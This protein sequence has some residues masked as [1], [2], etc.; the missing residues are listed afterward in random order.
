MLNCPILKTVYVLTLTQPKAL[1]K[2]RML[3][4]SAVVF[5]LNHAFNVTRIY[6]WPTSCC[7]LSSLIRFQTVCHRCFQNETANDKAD[8]FRNS[9]SVSFVAIYNASVNV[10]CWSLLLHVNVYV[11]DSLRHADK[12]C[13]PQSD[14]EPHCLLQ[15]FKRTS[16]QL[17]ADDI[18]CESGSVKVSF[19]SRERSS[20]SWGSVEKISKYLPRCL[21]KGFQKVVCVHCVVFHIW[22]YFTRPH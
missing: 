7:S 22:V 3:M 21:L 6:Y 12:Q 2:S 17:T 14:L 18:S 5:R 10:D 19:H 9:E 11:N 16:R 13:G 8:Y 20:S 15:G 1:F 4:S